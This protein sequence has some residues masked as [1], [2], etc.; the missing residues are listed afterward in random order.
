[1]LRLAS[2]TDDTYEPYAKTNQ[3]LTEDT[4]ALLDNTKVNGAV[5]MSPNN[6]TTQTI[7][8]ITWTVN[9]DG[10]VTANGT[11][12]SDW[13][14]RYSF[15]PSLSLQLFN[16]GCAEYCS[17]CLWY[18]SSKWWMDCWALASSMKSWMSL[19]RE[20]PTLSNAK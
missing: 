13:G 7:N 18:V 5:N 1:M 15:T 2:I 20:H 11:S 16:M 10:S 19:E 4:T 17:F 3:Q 12:T 8:G 6:F 14:I 9:D